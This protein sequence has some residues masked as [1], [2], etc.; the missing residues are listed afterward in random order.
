[1]LGGKRSPVP[2]YARWDVQAGPGV[3]LVVE[4][5]T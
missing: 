5:L 1:M 4:E 2:S 3:G